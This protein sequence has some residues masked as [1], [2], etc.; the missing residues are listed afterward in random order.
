MGVERMLL[1]AGSDQADQQLLA[2]VHARQRAVRLVGHDARTVASHGVRAGPAVHQPVLGVVGPR[3]QND[4]SGTVLLQLGGLK[5]LDLATE[6]SETKEAL[7]ALASLG[8]SKPEALAVLKTIDPQLSLK[9][10]LHQAIKLLGSQH[11]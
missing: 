10:R 1:A 7:A 8:F 9:H 4:R 5:D 3:R 11:D 6:S 2:G